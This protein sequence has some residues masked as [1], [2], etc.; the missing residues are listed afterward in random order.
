M[1]SITKKI[2]LLLVLSAVLF[3]SSCLKSGEQSYIGNEEF[4]YITQDDKTGTIYARTLGGYFITSEKI[5]LLTPGTT[6]FLTYQIT[7]ETEK[8]VTGENGNVTIFKSAMGA[9]PISISQ[10]TLMF[11]DAPN[12]PIVYFENLIKPIFTS[13]EY[14]GDRWLI[15]YTANV[16]KGEN[17]KVN[18]YK[19]NVEASTANTNEEVI[20]DVRLVKSGEAESGATD[21]LETKVV[22]ANFSSLR[23]MFKG[24][25]KEK[26]NIKFRFYRTANKEEIYTTSEIFSMQLK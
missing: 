17:M 13:N 5:N 2:S 16:K 24:S 15:G 18:F 19:T 21:K 4:S 8:I 3:L 14:F 23:A 20:I 10:S 1:K 22:T 7:E 9:E 12:V 6:A 25:D 26:I 11:T